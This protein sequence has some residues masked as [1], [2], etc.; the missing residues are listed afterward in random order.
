MT[1]DRVL[2]R[3]DEQVRRGAVAEPGFRVERAGPI[4][5]IVGEWNCVLFSRLT[6]ASADAE[7]AAQQAYFRQ[8]RQKFAWKLYA[9]DRPLDLGERLQR[10]G[11]APAER[12]TFVVF[13]LRNPLPDS[14]PPRGRIL[15]VEDAAGLADLAA[16]GERAFGFDY[17]AL[18]GEFAARMRLGTVSFYVAYVD[19]VPA[20][21]GRLEMPPNSEFAGLYGGGTAPEYRRRG[22]YR[23]LVRARA[24][25]ALS[26][27][28]RYL[29]L[30][31]EDTSL[32]IL[33]RMGFVPLT[34]V[35]D[36]E[37]VPETLAER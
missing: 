25:E 28:Y 22:L 20:S 13:D 6:E 24:E 18:S 3:F 2:V 1:P 37:W 29:N 8:L 23:A 10:A 7:I 33:L 27:G 30:D 21:A 12:E 5:R 15:R 32:P 36:W 14:P 35:Q 17:S 16:V 31:A 11:F 9:H 34:T 4:V 26:R 19:G